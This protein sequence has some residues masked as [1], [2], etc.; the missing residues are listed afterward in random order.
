M[1]IQAIVVKKP[2]QAVKAEVPI[3]KLRDDYILVKVKTAALNPANW[4]YLEYLTDIGSRA[5]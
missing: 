3:P 5:G 4:K 2:R 1:S